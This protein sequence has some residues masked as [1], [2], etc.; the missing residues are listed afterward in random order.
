[1]FYIYILYS[2]SSDIYYVGHSE[3]PWRRLEEH[4]LS[5]HDTFTAK[6][7]PWNLVAIFETVGNRKDAMRIERFIKKQKSKVLLEQL[8][9]G[10]N[11]YGE[12]AQ[13][14][15]PQMRDACAGLIRGSLVQVQSGEP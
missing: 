1:M 12:L 9:E 15:I 7:R 13:L 5:L 8:I 2:A 11:L 10:Q 6:H 14:V 3:N 4:N